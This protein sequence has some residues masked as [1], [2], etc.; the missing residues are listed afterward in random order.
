[1][2]G[3]DKLLGFFFGILEGILLIFLIVYLLNFQTFFDMANLTRGSELIPY[4][5]RF[6]PA[7]DNSSQKIL[8]QMNI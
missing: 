8:E 6:L 5:E 1:M 7:L 2:E 3:M 4:I